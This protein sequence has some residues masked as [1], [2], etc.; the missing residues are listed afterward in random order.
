MCSRCALDGPIFALRAGLAF[1]L[2]LAGPAIASAGTITVP[3]D[4]SVSLTAEPDID[5]QSGQRITFTLSM[6]NHGPEPVTLADV[7]S[8]SIY[9]ELDPNAAT[10]DCG[11]TLGLIVV[12][13]ND[14]FYYAYDW[15][16]T[17]HSPLAIGET[18]ICHLN[19]SFTEWAPDA[20]S[21]TFSMPYWLVDLGPSNNS[22]TVV[23]RR[24]VLGTG[25]AAVPTLSPVALVILVGLLACIG[26]V[27]RRAIATRSQWSSG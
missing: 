16:P 26:S 18:R 8:S 7:L 9:D 1:C 12:D 6:T 15:D 14:G 21:L 25:A 27:A 17:L 4:L 22:A 2:Y 5:L 10:A 13:L 11:D 19:L 3:A 24:S 20:F 23:L